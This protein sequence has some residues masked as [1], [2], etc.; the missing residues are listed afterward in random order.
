MRR[1][2]TLALVLAACGGSGGT[3]GV[4][5][6][7]QA[8]ES[9]DSSSGQLHIEVRSSPQPPTRGK[10]AF[11]LTVKDGSGNA[12]SGEQLAIQLWMP[13][14]GHGSSVTPAVVDQ[15]NGVFEVDDCYF[16]MAGTWQ[17]R[18]TFTGK[19]SDD[20]TASVQIP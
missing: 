14:M 6:P 10:N 20:A 4:S 1:V 19:Q 11:Q 5:F 13:D 12:V 9:V 3:Q 2:A 7:A 17:L 16:A 8:L 15:G 18:M